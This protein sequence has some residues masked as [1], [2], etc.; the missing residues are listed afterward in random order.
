MN[1]LYIYILTKYFI[2]FSG[3]AIA[4][5]IIEGELLYNLRTSSFD[6]F[7]KI[8]FSI[9]LNVLGYGFFLHLSI[10]SFLIHSL[11]YLINKLK[12]IIKYIKN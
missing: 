10:L 9:S 5:P 8:V 1:L 2:I 7:S 4:I 12:K 11:I 6:I 3:L